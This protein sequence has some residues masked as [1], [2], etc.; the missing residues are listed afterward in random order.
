MIGDN[1]A[2]DIAGAKRA[3]LDAIVVL[4]GATEPGELEQ[5]TARPD[6]VLPSL[7]ALA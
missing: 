4:S 7:A 2:T 3:G 1:L 5:A 6:F